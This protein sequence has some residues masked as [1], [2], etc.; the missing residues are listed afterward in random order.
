MATQETLL[1]RYEEL[2]RRVEALPTEVN[3]WRDRSSGQLDLNAHF[4]QLGALEV[5]M[6]GYIERQRS[7]LAELKLLEGT[8]EFMAKAFELTNVIIKS[9]GVW[10]YFRD[11]LELRFS[12]TFKNVLWIADTV[13]WDSYLPVLERAAD[14]GIIPRS[15]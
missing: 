2:R 1:I 13:A 5:L 8:E 14:E 10:D 7:L 11:M 9:Q 6:S 12:P 15:K 4:S 3:G